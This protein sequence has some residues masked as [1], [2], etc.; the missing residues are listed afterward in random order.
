MVE[1]RV[2]ID[3]QGRP[4]GRAPITDAVRAADGRLL[5]RYAS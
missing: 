2:E 1:T 3:Y 4:I 5:Q